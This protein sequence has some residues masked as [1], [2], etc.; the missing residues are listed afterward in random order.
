MTLGHATT[1]TRRGSVGRGRRRAYRRQRVRR[2]L[3]FGLQRS[4]L[5]VG[6][7]LGTRG[8]YAAVFPVPPS[9]IIDIWQ[10]GRPEYDRLP[11]L[12]SS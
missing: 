5:F 10:P 12:P 1:R 8:N 9:D 6:I 4:K 3:R 2:E 11:G 7:L